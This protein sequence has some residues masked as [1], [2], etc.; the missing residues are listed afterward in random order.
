MNL[1]RNKEPVLQYSCCNED[2]QSEL[3]ALEVGGKRVLSIAAAGGRAL[4]LLL[5]DPSSVLAVD[6]NPAQVHLG[7]LKVAAIAGLERTD[8]LAFVGISPSATRLA[9]YERLRAELDTEARGYW[10]GRR[11]AIAAGI[12]HSGRCERSIAR[13]APVLRRLLARDI[14]RLQA[15]QTLEEQGV[16]AEELLQR[17]PVR[18]L[19][20]LI[21]N[22]LS[23]R[24][25][26]RDPVY[27]GEAR[28]DAGAYLRARLIESLQNHRMDECFVLN[29]FLDGHLK[30]SKSLPL[31][32]SEGNYQLVR[33][34]LDRIRFETTDVIEHLR[35]QDPA[36]L[37]AFSLSDLGGY[38]TTEQFSELLAQVERVASPRASVC[39]R[40]YISAP[41][42]RATW[43][44]ALSRNRDL[45]ES[46]L[47]SDRSVGCTF[48]V[49]SR[50][51]GVVG[52]SA[53]L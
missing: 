7:R 36:S 26:L 43:P 21:F 15:T 32:L 16:L 41:T 1:R 24:F 39:I 2:T 34:R 40:E 29:L 20:S 14:A 33:S 46:L 10:D 17:Y 48:V 35:K 37:D 44:R 27:Y 42:V 52:E 8:Y 51:Q 50:S 31:H 53:G 3:Q 28:R 38:L 11:A 22:P 45:E 18:L 6:R 5:G 13:V 49:A 23:G 19:M 47:K 30:K 4:S 25:V 9:V 12:L